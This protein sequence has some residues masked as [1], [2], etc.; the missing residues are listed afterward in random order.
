MPLEAPDLLVGIGVPD[1][2]RTVKSCRRQELAIPAPGHGVNR[3][4]VPF[5]CPL[6]LAATRLDRLRLRQS[7]S[8]EPGV[9]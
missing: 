1:P 4:C 9:A 6:E 2:D 8:P 3:L 7:R 5:K